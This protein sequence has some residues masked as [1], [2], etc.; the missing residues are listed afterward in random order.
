ME[1]RASFVAPSARR[2][3]RR[4]LGGVFTSASEPLVVQPAGR[5]RYEDR[6]Q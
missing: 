6:F 2:L 3:D 5:R 1:E 4:R